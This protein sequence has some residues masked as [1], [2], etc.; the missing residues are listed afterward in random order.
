MGHSMNNMVGLIII[1]I[2]AIQ[3]IK[4]LHTKTMNLWIEAKK[5]LSHVMFHV[6]TVTYHL[7]PALPTFLAMFHI[8]S[9]APLENLPYFKYDGHR[10]VSGDRKLVYCPLKK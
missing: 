1:T 3:G 5:S 6:L 9:G 8:N 2:V 10:K 7:S 4:I